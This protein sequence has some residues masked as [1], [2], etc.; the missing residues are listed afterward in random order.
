MKEKIAVFESLIGDARK[1]MKHLADVRGN[2][3]A[4]KYSMESVGMGALSIF[5]AK[6]R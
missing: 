2:S 5:I 1:V 4:T 6:N 3:N